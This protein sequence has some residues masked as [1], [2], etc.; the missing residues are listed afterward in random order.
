MRPDD[1]NMAGNVH[2]GT[3]LKMIEE[4]GVII[5]TRH[6]NSQ[7]GVSV[8]HPSP[9]LAVSA[10]G[11]GPQEARCAFVGRTPGNA[12]WLW[13]QQGGRGG[14]RQRL[15]QELPTA[16][17]KHL[18]SFLEESWFLLFLEPGLTG[19]GRG[20]LRLPSLVVSS[21]LWL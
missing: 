10:E 18:P 6:C 21:R 4:A 12:V 9:G 20:C 2:G 14:D 3:I 5:S 7:N 19:L 13:A 15:S 8:W 16:T 1:A 17:L 11:P